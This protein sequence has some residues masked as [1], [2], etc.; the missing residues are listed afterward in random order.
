MNSEDWWNDN[1][2]GQTEVLG[3]KKIII[4]TMYTTYP[5]RTM[6]PLA[7]GTVRLDSKFSFGFNTNMF[8]P[9]D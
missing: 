9:R 3:N 1:S 4:V 2:Q 8:P 5:T 7:F 6:E